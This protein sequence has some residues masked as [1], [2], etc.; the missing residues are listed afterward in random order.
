MKGACHI[1]SETD[2]RYRRIVR[3]RGRGYPIMACRNC[4]PF[5]D[6]RLTDISDPMVQEELDSIVRRVQRLRRKREK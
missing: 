3:H 4:L 2:E 6:E 1:C 5:V